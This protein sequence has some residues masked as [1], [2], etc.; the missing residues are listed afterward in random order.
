[1]IRRILITGGFG[2]VGSRVAQVIAAQPDTHVI[3]GSREH[4]SPPA[5]LPG[6]STVATP[7]SDD[8]GLKRA[9]SKVDTVLHLA[10][11]NEVDALSNPVGALEMNGVNS[12][13]LLEAAKSEGVASFIYLST[14]H[15]YAA[16]LSG[17][18]DE[19]TLPRPRHPYASSH[20]AA[21]DA[22]LAAY[23]EGKITGI[24]LRLSNGFGA[25]AHAG[26][27]RW[28]LLIN[29]LCRQAVMHRKL[30]M[31]SSGLQ[32]RDFVTLHDVGR[33]FCHVIDLPV[34]KIGNGI[35]NVGGAWSPRIIDMV[36][37]VQKRCAIVLGFTPE[38][39][40]PA[41]EPGEASADLNYSIEK[42]LATGFALTGDPAH[43]IDSTL[44]FCRDLYGSSNG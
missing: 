7:W 3:L 9:C 25:P 11:M 2:Y 6:A 26:V 21:E 30:T 31:R 12:V 4:K 10:A 43:E 33:A 19:S 16:P 5:W 36:E 32:R 8:D 42:L 15:V 13:R 41:A 1:M 39:V 37:L 24:V 44:V 28:T 38:I 23:D 29:D 14:A 27:N 22:V 35:F 34:N 40:S 17:H 18:I 20:R